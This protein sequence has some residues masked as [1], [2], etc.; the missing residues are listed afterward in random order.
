MTIR[1]ASQS[2]AAASGLLPAL[3]VVLGLSAAGPAGA[4]P[5]PSLLPY[6]PPRAAAAPAGEEPGPASGERASEV[7]GGAAS[8]LRPLPASPSPLVFP[9]EGGSLSWPV[10]LTA[11]QA[12]GPV[13]LRAGHVTALSV[14]PDTSALVARVNGVVVGRAPI[15]AGAD[16]AAAPEFEVPAHL[17]QRGFNLVGLAAEQSHRVDCSAAATF[18]LW[19]RLDPLATGLVLPPG[20]AGPTDLADLPALRPRPDGALRIA[21]LMPGRMAPALAERAVRA[22]QLVA[23]AAGTLH[24]VV[25]IVASPSAPDGLVLA[26]GTGADLAA[27]LGEGEAALPGTGAVLLPPRSGAAPLLV[28]SGPTLGDLDAA[29]AGLEEAAVRVASGDALPGAP[30]ALRLLRAQQGRAAAAPG[31]V[32]LA[33]DAA[34]AAFSG[35]R[36]VLHLD[37]TLPADLLPADYARAQLSLRGLVAPDVTSGARLVVGLNGTETIAAPLP[38]GRGEPGDLASFSLPLGLFRPGPNRLSLT[39]ELPTAADAACDPT[40]PPGREP[41]LALDPASGLDMPA[42]ARVLR[43]PE[44]AQV[45]NGMLPFVLPGARAVLHVPRPDRGAME[46]ALTLAARAAVAAG[47]AVPFRFSL[48]PPEPG[49]VAITVAAAEAVPA[50]TLRGVGIDPAA[51]NAAW[52]RLPPAPSGATACGPAGPDADAPG[53][54]LPQTAVA[55]EDP[56]A[57]SGRSP[58]AEARAWASAALRRLAGHAMPAAAIRDGRLREVPFAPATA[59]VVA[60]SGS[61]AAGGSRLLVLG[62]DGAGMAAAMQCL[63]APAAWAQLRGRLAT[64]TAAGEVAAGDDAL[65]VTFAANRDWSPGHVRRLLAGWFALNPFAYIG[66]TLLA[67]GWLGAATLVVVKRSGRPQA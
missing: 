57:G 51:L 61:D 54:A 63:A 25:E 4:Q 21:L 11:A 37:L 18:E 47:A 52:S 8:A 7:R 2:P 48:A 27:L 30:G 15:D 53:R 45:A 58:A 40:L 13:L 26:L 20:A 50:A 31:R 60:Q 46:T 6:Q 3:A 65:L 22:V 1:R 23:L 34:A 14:R 19:T 16:P 66:A 55:A 36:G 10:Y 24:P 56:P 32:A 17:L 59:L 44:L 29:L 42:L 33:D 35:R 5:A 9:G 43:M 39:A 41:R 49:D 67:A 64:V 28:V 12:R 62:R 38:R